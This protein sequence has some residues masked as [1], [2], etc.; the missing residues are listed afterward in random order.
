MREKLAVIRQT[1]NCECEWKYNEDL[2]SWG[3]QCNSWFQFIDDDERDFKFCPYCS[4][5]IRE[6]EMGSTN[7]LGGN[8]AMD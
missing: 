2:S 6:V 3:T 1:E 7:S 5:K 4:K 8:N